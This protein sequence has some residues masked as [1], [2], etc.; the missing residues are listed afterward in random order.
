MSGQCRPREQL[1][2]C[3][4]SR[5]QGVRARQTRHL[6]LRPR[7][8]VRPTRNACL[9]PGARLAPDSCQAEKEGNGACVRT[10]THLVGERRVVVCA[11]FGH[12]LLLEDGEE[13]ATHRSACMASIGLG[14]Y[15]HHCHEGVCGITFCLLAL[16]GESSVLRR[17][18]PPGAPGRGGGW[19]E[20]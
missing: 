19:V 15:S 14:R 2:G 12:G 7:A 6:S 18:G 1:S 16:L 8:R 20:G 5:S 13:P 9:F 4:R 3:W 11:V 10:K 17:S